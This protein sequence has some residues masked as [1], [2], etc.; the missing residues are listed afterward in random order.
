MP[1]FDE[2]TPK[3]VDL[4]EAL[5]IS[6]GRDKEYMKTGSSRSVIDHFFDKLIHIALPKEIDNPFVI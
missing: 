6:K 2:K 5:E 4:N 1:L 3:P